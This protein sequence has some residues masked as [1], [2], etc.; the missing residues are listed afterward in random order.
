MSAINT[1]AFALGSIIGPLFG[2]VLTDALNFRTAFLILGCFFFAFLILMAALIA[3]D[4]K[5]TRRSSADEEDRRIG[6]LD[7]EN[8]VELS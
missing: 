3:F 5:Q 1:G 8:L 6:M 7:A 4:K 2:S